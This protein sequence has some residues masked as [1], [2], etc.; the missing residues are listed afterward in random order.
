MKSILIA[1]MA[2][3]AAVSFGF[4]KAATSKALNGLNKQYANAL[5]KK[6]ISFFEKTAAPDFV[7]IEKNGKK[8][9]RAAA[10][11]Q[12][13]Q[14][15]GMPTKMVS[16]S[17]KLV[18]FTEKG[19]TVTAITESKMVAKLPGQKKGQWS[20]LKGVSKDEEVWTHKGGKW[21]IHSM[22]T[23]SESQTLDGKPMPGM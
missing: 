18:S 1:A 13:K 5:M 8:M 14:F 22:K 20:T 17:G 6:D 3:L 16:A 19:D 10:I 12:I 23:I 15:F 4:D 21:L 7:E 11:A 9:D 2:L